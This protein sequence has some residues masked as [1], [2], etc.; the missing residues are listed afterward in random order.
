M[1]QYHS[2]WIGLLLMLG[3]AGCK[4]EKID[5]SSMPYRIELS[6]DAPEVG[7]PNR[8]VKFPVQLFVADGI[9]KAEIRQDFRVI[10]G[11][12]QTFEGRPTATEYLF[13]FVPKRSD[14]GRTLNFT[15]VVYGSQG[16]TDTTPYKLTI[17]EAPL[18]IQLMLP[19]EPPIEAEVGDVLAFDIGVTSELALRQIQTLLDGT[20]LPE[21][22][23]T[24]FE[25]PLHV[26]YPFTYTVTED[27][28]GKTLTFT[29]RATDM[30][31]K[32]Q[33]ATYVVEVQGTRPAQP[34]NVYEDVLL[35]GQRSTEN[36]HFL[37]TETGQAYFS[38]GVAAVCA[39]IDLLHFVSGSATGVNIAAPSFANA[40][41]VYSA[42][43]SNATDALSAWPV[44]NATELKRLD[45]L[46]SSDFEALST[47]DQVVH[48]FEEGGEAT[49]NINRIAVN[50]MIALKTT[51]GRYGILWVKELPAGNTG[52]IRFDL[53]MQK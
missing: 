16:H 25:N 32:V 39:E 36:G 1:T 42:A 51:D 28:I 26:Q 22:K 47:D 14:L 35:G 10:A 15:V 50:D 27:A 45:G 41:I 53:K 18:N 8:A 33:E 48:L 7:Y 40:P 23:Q 5:A 19:D 31:E 37:N 9:M 24:E 6:T 38:P 12:E 13:E 20:E 29:F 44:R 30:E 17:Q 21:L 49:D 52:S 43:H 2:F 3:I 11:S 34:V 46:S 4:E